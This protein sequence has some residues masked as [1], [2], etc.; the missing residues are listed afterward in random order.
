MLHCFGMS[1]GT[2]LAMLD[3]EMVDLLLGCNRPMPEGIES[4]IHSIHEKGDAHP[5]V[6]IV[7]PRGAQ[8][9]D[10]HRQLSWVV[11]AKIR[12]CH[13]HSG[14]ASAIMLNGILSGLATQENTYIVNRAS[15]LEA[16]S[17]APAIEDGS[18]HCCVHARWHFLGN[19]LQTSWYAVHVM[20]WK[21]PQSIWDAPPPFNLVSYPI[22]T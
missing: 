3:D 5:R 21:A 13:L 18:K 20:T 17:G 10:V 7:Q 22:W 12:P 4:R 1:E 2:L 16:P 9:P 15:L 8:K 6:W 19:H 14:R 11:K